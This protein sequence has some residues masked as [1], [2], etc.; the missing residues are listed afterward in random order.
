VIARNDVAHW[1]D[2]VC[3]S[4]GESYEGARTTRGSLLSLPIYPALT[5]HEVE[6]V[7]AAVRRVH[8]E[9]ERM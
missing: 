3:P 6:Q 2:T 7:V 9:L 8:A 4:P 5:D 1:F